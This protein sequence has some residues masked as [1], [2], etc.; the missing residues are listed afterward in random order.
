MPGTLK[1][2]TNAWTAPNHRA[3]VAILVYWVEA[4]I[5]KITVLDLVDVPESHT[6]IAL[7]NTFESVLNSFRIK[8]KVSTGCREVE[9]KLTV[10]Q[11]HTVTADNAANNDIM[12]DELGRRIPSFRGACS[13]VCCFCHILNLG[14][15]AILRQFDAP[16]VK[17]GKIL[18]DAK[19]VL[20]SLMEGVNLNEDWSRRTEALGTDSSENNA[21]GEI[22]VRE[23]MLQE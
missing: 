17:E 6:G 15:K 11:F 1:F 22:D 18:N 19:T 14:A 2:G 20:A 3:W 16:K 21:E 7:A 8:E 23:G 12:V 5:R 10:L 9:Y 13:H 4:H